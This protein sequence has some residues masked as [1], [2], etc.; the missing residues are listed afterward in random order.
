[1]VMWTAGLSSWHTVAAA[2]IAIAHKA[3]SGLIEKPGAYLRGMTARAARG[4]LLLGK[5]FH[6]IRDEQAKRHSAPEAVRTALAARPSPRA[7]RNAQKLI[8]QTASRWNTKGR[9]G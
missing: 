1:M 2:M 8:R 7:F 9:E 6:G 3:D 5:T 4:E